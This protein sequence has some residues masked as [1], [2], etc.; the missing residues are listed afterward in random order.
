MYTFFRVLSD[1]IM[2]SNKM[3][4]LLCMSV[5]LF[6]LSRVSTSCP[7]HCVCNATDLECYTTLP[8]FI[9]ENVSSV[10]AH[11]VPLKPYL[12]FTY[13]DWHSVT[14]L[15]LSL[16]NVNK[17]KYTKRRLQ[18]YEFTGLMNLKHLKL[19][20]NCI[21]SV[22]SSAFY[23]LT[24][25]TVLDLSNN[26]VDLL[27][28]MS[29]IVAA[30]KGEDILP[31]ISELYLSNIPF[32]YNPT[33]PLYLD[34]D[35]LHTAMENKPLQVLDL[36]G[37]NFRF[38]LSPNPTSPPLLL[39]QLHTL[40]ISRAGQAVFSLS[41]IYRYY[42][43]RPEAVFSDLQVLDASYPYFPQ[44][45]SECEKSYYYRQFCKTGQRTT[46]F[47]PSNL[48]DLYIPNIFA[49]QI[50]ELRGE[51]NSTHL[52]ITTKIFSTNRTIC[53]GVNL[54]HLRHLDLSNNSF[55]Y[56]QTNLIQPLKSLRQLNFINNNIGHAL[57][58]GKYA[59][60][61]FQALKSTEVLLF[62]NNSITFLPSKI[63]KHNTKL[64]ILDLSNNGLTSINLGINGQVLLELLDLSNNSIVS[65]ESAGCEMLKNLHFSL[66]TSNTS[67][68][69]NYS[70]TGLRLEENPLTCSCDNICLFKFLQDQNKT[71]TCTSNGKVQIADFLFVKHLEYTCKKGIVIATFTIDAILTVIIIGL[72]IPVIRKER[73]RM[74]FK[75]LKESGIEQYSTARKKY[76]VF[77]SFSGDDSE[78]V[79]TRVYPQLEAELKRILNTESDCVATGGT[80]FR[81]GHAIQDEIVRC[82]EE[83]SVVIF[84][85]SDT[86]INKSW[87]RS[88]V[89]KAF[90]DEKAI[91]LMILGKLNLKSMPRVLRKHY[92]TFTRVH[93]SIES[94]QYVMRPNMEHFCETIVGLIGRGAD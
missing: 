64:R 9:P 15:S 74:K 79:M 62:P 89:H 1:K 49:S 22:N 32:W 38:F 11:E 77:L 16:G 23:G 41:D 93:W 37:T 7:D 36:S 72:A 19:L 17:T 50:H 55:T 26:V 57:A 83:S 52:C 66:N 86:F 20:C 35:N 68:P 2:Q 18:D 12:N 63:L 3:T 70:Q 47:L 65:V 51:F 73:R 58:D 87:C 78:F 44:S 10:T 14:Y 69:H 92:E 28:D 91:V 90:C 40:N 4:Y 13:T 8:S 61:F 42:T 76:V 81:P 30:L 94:G 84:F 71:L 39:P 24:N 29:D 27:S 5:I 60:S 46:N 21:M 56:I 6:T 45:Q 85:L 59:R 25:V 88:E 54:K 33:L 48:T 34:L 43:Q 53:V 67:M 75:K 82:V 80:H 31:S